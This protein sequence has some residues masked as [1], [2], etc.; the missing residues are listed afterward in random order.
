MNRRVSIGVLALALAS[1]GCFTSW[2]AV[3]ASNNARY[4]EEGARE[5]IVPQPGVREY[6]RV[7]LPVVHPGADAAGDPR[8]L[9]LACT[10]TQ[11]GQDRVHRSAFRYGSGWKKATALGFLLEGLAATG[12]Y[13]AAR[14]DAD[15]GDPMREAAAPATRVVAGI[16]AADALGTAVLFF[17][18]RKE[19]FRTETR[20]AVTL[21]RE[22][23]PDGL[24]LEIAGE[25]FKVDAA[26]RIGELGEAA[27]DAYMKAPA[28]AVR[29]VYAGAT[30][31][32]RI[33]AIDQCTWLRTHH[34]D[35]RC[36]QAS[37][38]VNQAVLASLELPL[39][40]LTRID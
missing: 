23:C 31:D 1:S 37:T 14:A 33:S 36:V 17:L 20:P 24:L 22:D 40:T 18:P 21:V 12:F 19:V 6:L 13:F 11:S 8:P 29:V 27:L 32:L 2:V 16:I 15:S 39:G 4:L 9:A 38:S 28:G 10:S 3:Q 35:E 34:A 7:A 30:S 26:G 5:E 25:S